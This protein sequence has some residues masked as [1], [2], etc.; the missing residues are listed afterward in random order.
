T[1]CQLSGMTAAFITANPDNVLEA[2]AAAVCAMGLAG[3]IAWSKMQDGD[4]NS[5]YRNRIIDAIYNMD[6]KQLEDGAKY[7]IR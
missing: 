7:E 1:G 3:E 2:A 5:T 4:G 6:G